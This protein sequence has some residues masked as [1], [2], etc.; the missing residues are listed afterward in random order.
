MKELSLKYLAIA[1]IN[2]VILTLLQ[3]LWTDKLELILNNWFRP[4]EFLKIWGATVISVSGIWLFLLYTKRRSIN[5][6][7][8]KLTGAI[9]VTLIASSYLY[10]TYIQKAVRNILVN[11]T[12]PKSTI[13]KIRSGNLLANGT[14]ADGLS[15][16][17]YRELAEMNRFP[18]VP[19]QAQNIEYSYQYDG[20]LPDYSFTLL[21]EL[22]KG[23]KV[24]S[25]NYTEKGISRNQSVDTLENTIRVIYTEVVY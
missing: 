14:M 8:F 24:D 16:Y 3:A 6:V 23:V 22:P 12:H 2:M 25:F 11:E 17:E 19:D 4:I 18:P 20:F 1:A 13:S 10:T 9:M 15:L 7:K 5:S 21:Y